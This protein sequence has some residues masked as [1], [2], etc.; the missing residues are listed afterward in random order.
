MLN[1][2]SEHWLLTGIASFV[3]ACSIIA[4]HDIVQKK[5]T[6]LH[7]FPIVGHLRYFLEMIGP[8]L[9]QYWVA[10]DKEEMPFNRDERKWIYASAKEANNN[11]GFGSTEQMYGVGYPIVKHAAFPFPDH[12]AFHIGGDPSA[13]RAIVWRVW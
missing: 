9:R 2:L 7:N 11:F 13:V 12:H 10:N 4:L 1:F 3:A 6:I 8:E 5:H